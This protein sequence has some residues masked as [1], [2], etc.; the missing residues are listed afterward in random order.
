MKH[1]EKNIPNYFK[2]GIYYRKNICQGFLENLIYK[3]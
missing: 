2:Y 1:F 3:K